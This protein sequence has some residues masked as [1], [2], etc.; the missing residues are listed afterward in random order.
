MFVESYLIL[1]DLLGGDW[2]VRP[3]REKSE[4]T[5]AKS[6]NHMGHDTSIS[7]V[8]THCKVTVRCGN[9]L[10][11]PVWKMK[12]K[13]IFHIYVRLPGRE[14][15]SKRLRTEPGSQTKDTE[16]GAVDAAETRLP[17]DVRDEKIGPRWLRSCSI[18][19]ERKLWWC[20]SSL[21]MSNIS[22]M[23]LFFGKQWKTHQ[24]N[25]DT[26]WLNHQQLG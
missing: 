22:T 6:S 14:I 11:K 1:Y 18:T 13:W 15:C 7:I 21:R 24:M 19:G 3:L 25:G 9:W 17:V 10:G 16:P 8:G 26:C 20:S 23:T 4:R 2:T 5:E 12:C